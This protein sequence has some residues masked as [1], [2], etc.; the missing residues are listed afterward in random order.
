[1]FLHSYVIFCIH[2]VTEEYTFFDGKVSMSQNNIMF[3]LNDVIILE[4]DFTVRRSGHV[5]CDVALSTT[6]HLAMDR[7]GRTRGQQ[8]ATS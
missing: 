6:G 4:R 7:H 1:M 3:V 2:K 8:P 5:S